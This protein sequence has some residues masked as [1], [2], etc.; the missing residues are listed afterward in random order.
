MPRPPRP[1]SIPEQVAELWRAVRG[2]R[3]TTGPITGGLIVGPAG[4]PGADGAPGADGPPGQDGAQGPPGESGTGTVGGEP[5]ICIVRHSVAET[6]VGGVG[7]YQ[8]YDTDESDDSHMHS[9]S[10]PAASQRT[11]TVLEDGHFV[12]QATTEFTN[13]SNRSTL[14]L[15]RNRAGVLTIVDLDRV[16]P[17]SSG[18]GVLRCFRVMECLAGD[19]FR[20]LFTTNSNGS[21]V[22]GARGPM[23]SVEKLT[24][25]PQGPTGATGA[26]GATGPPGAT[27]LPTCIVRHS[28]AQTISTTPIY[29][30]YN[31]E[32]D[33]LDGMHSSGAPTIINVLANGL[34]EIQA[35][36]EFTSAST[37][38]VLEIEHN[39]G[40]TL[41]TVDVDRKDAPSS[42]NGMVRCFRRMRC[43]AGDSFR[44]ECTASATG[45]T[46]AAD[47]GPMFSVAKIRD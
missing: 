29:Q 27:T 30:S 17:P 16:D 3:G 11:I 47:R 24:V 10:G 12:I 40:G 33:D 35:C 22:V 37:R 34:Y 8:R 38:V 45:A 5:A 4:P 2:L 25:G 32:E 36:T 7:I 18:N 15:E 46:V 1:Q 41:T 39:R 31:T 6:T 14:Q 23:F 19:S 44:I 20:V 42:G 13:G 28:V 9:A 21:T 43:L 26:T